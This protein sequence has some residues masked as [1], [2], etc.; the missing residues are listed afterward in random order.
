MPLRFAE[1]YREKAVEVV[2]APVAVGENKL[3]V[4]QRCR[5]GIEKQAGAA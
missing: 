3:P 1:L 5:A 2:L 4:C